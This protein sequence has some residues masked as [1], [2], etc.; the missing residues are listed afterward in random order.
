LSMSFSSQKVMAQG[1]SYGYGM[2]WCQMLASGMGTYESEKIIQNNI[3]N[4]VPPSYNTDVNAPWNRGLGNQLGIGIGSAIVENIKKNQRENQAVPGVAATM[5]ANCPEYFKSMENKYRL[6]KGKGEPLLVIGLSD[7]EK[8]EACKFNRFDKNCKEWIRG[9]E[10]L[11][12][13]SSSKANSINQSLEEKLVE[14]KQL[15]DKD[16]ISDEEYLVMRSKVLGL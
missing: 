3:R 9:Y 5:E 6:D 1:G 11:L 14:L 2:Q 10:K 13:P 16:L 7:K 12:L 8:Y 15:L 4:S